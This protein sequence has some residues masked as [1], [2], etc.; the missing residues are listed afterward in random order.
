MISPAREWKIGNGATRVDI[1]GDFPVEVSLLNE[2]TLYHT[3][4]E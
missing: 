2:H 4:A 1:S 3:S